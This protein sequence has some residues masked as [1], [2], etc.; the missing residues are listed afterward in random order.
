MERDDGARPGRAVSE[1]RLGHWDGHT[2]HGSQEQGA[3]QLASAHFSIPVQCDTGPSV[4]WGLLG[5][6]CSLPMLM[7]VSPAAALR[8]VLY[9]PTDIYSLFV[10]TPIHPPPQFDL[11]VQ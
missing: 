5:V 9:L 10:N 1:E 8:S 11:R 3:R 6:W 7:P 2:D 4:K